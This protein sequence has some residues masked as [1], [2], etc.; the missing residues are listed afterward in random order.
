MA[1][2][3]QIF[4]RGGLGIDLG[5]DAVM[6][7]RAGD[8]HLALAGAVMLRLEDMQRARER[9]ATTAARW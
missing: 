9:I 3:P 1:R 7:Q 8:D 4:L 6:R 2:Q 5:D